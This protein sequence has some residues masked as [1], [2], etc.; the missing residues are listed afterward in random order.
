MPKILN[1]DIPVEMPPAAQAIY[2]EIENEFTV[3]LKSGERID[4]V[5]AAGVSNKL[6]QILAGAVY[7][8]P[9]HPEWKHIHD[10]K[11]DKLAEVVDDLQGEPLLVFTWFRF[12]REMIQKRIASARD[13]NV[14]E[15]NK[16][17]IP[18]MVLNPAS[19]GHGL[20]LQHGGSTVLFYSLPWSSE[21]YDQGIGRLAR[22][23][24]KSPF[25]TVSNLTVRGSMDTV[26]AQALAHKHSV[27][28]AVL[29]AVKR[30]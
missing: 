13:L 9:G 2:E 22:I 27:Q 6:R 14:V 17:N 7:L 12:E 5:D 29:E 19:A 21:Y 24:Q 4:A 28:S 20:N 18:V 15:W 25:V 10:A 16:R 11:L 1:N 3:L 30:R 26:V 23:G 8:V